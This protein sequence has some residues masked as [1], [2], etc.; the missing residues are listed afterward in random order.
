M[1]RII[2]IVI[3]FVLISNSIH[4]NDDF[5]SCNCEVDRILSTFEK[6]KSKYILVLK[7]SIRISLFRDSI[8][9]KNKIGESD[10]DLDKFTYYINPILKLNKEAEIYN[11]TINFCKYFEIDTVT[12]GCEAG[13]FLNDSLYFYCKLGEFDCNNNPIHL[14]LMHHYYYFNEHNLNVRSKWYKSHKKRFYT[15]LQMKFILKGYPA[16]FFLINNNNLLIRDY[17]NPEKIDHD[18]TCNELREL[19]K[20]KWTRILVKTC[21]E[22]SNYIYGSFNTVTSTFSDF[23]KTQ[24]NQNGLSITNEV[25]SRDEVDIDEYVDFWNIFGINSKKINGIN[26]MNFS[27]LRG[28]LNEGPVFASYRIGPTSKSIIINAFQAWDD[29]TFKF[30]FVNDNNSKSNK[31]ESIQETDNLDIFDRLIGWQLYK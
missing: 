27:S 12:F 4:A 20:S 10:I 26:D 22:K 29:G 3:F 1:L 5:D 14:K 16:I 8:Y 25:N 15:D 6:Y 2:K 24:V 13:L 11:D 19:Y 17:S 28:A 31:N 9:E 21:Q 18:N 23:L 30:Y 7:D